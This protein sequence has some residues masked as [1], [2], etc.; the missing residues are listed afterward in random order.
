MVDRARSG[1]CQSRTVTFTRQ[2]STPPFVP[3]DATAVAVAPRRDVIVG[4]DTLDSPSVGYVVSLPVRPATVVEAFRTKYNWDIT[5][6][7][8]NDVGQVTLLEFRPHRWLFALTLPTVNED[9]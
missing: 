5:I 6:E 2:I 8:D 4:N 3:S 1:A 7:I 9:R